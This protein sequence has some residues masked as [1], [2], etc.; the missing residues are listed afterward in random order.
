MY[1][2]KTR[3]SSQAHNSA[4]ILLSFVYSTSISFIFC[5]TCV[6]SFQ[7]FIPSLPRDS[8]FA[9]GHKFY[10]FSCAYCTK[11][12]MQF[13]REHRNTKPNSRMVLPGFP[14]MPAAVKSPADVI[15]RVAEL[16]L[17][18]KLRSHEGVQVNVKCTPSD[19]MSGNLQGRNVGRWVARTY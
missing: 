3:C 4:I 15:G 6:Q 12:L 14:V 5:E 7:Y 11:S 2:P 9:P 17:K 13:E 18:L 1:A 16:G 8:L 10:S 19:L